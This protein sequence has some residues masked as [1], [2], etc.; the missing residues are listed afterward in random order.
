MVRY[1]LDPPDA[2]HPGAR[3]GSA[4]AVSTGGEDS[5]QSVG[6]TAPDRP[7]PRRAAVMILAWNSGEDLVR[8]VESVVRTLPAGM[9][10]VVLDNASEDGA[11]E[12]AAHSTP[13]VE[14]LQMGANLGFAAAYNR[15]IRAA[16][17][18]YVVLLNPDTTVAETGWVEALLDFADR[19]PQ[20]AAVACKMVFAR[21]PTRI[22]S[23]GAMAYWW[24]GPVDVGFGELDR[25]QYG[26][27]FRPFASSGGAMLVRRSRFL[28]VGGFDEATFAYGE[29]LDLCW[30]FRL[31]GWEIGFVPAALV[32][33]RFSSTLGPMSPTKVY[34][35]HRNYLRAMLCNYSGSTLVWA[36]AAYAMW[37]GVKLTGA[38]SIERSLRL[39]GSIVRA[40]GWNAVVLRDTR[41]AR[42]AIQS[43]RRVRDREI[44]RVMGPCGFE[45]LSS[46]ERRRR[47]A[48]GQLSEGDR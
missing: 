32:R 45:P 21:D 7:S 26:A 9:R 47:I 17:E 34:L 37:T 6:E 25:G 43:S 3:A 40:L 10:I 23:V 1:D 20:V 30:R 2:D 46:I 27:D 19:N 16:V 14:L 15:G 41:A 8:C 33:H 13:G 44:L 29:D 5:G 4:G 38:L 12:R 39:A 22:N 48:H 36:L 28:E 31:R 42:R 18:E 11:P 24:T 35:T